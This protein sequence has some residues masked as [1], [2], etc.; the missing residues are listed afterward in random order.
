MAFNQRIINLLVCQLLLVG[1]ALTVLGLAHLTWPH[2][3]PWSASGLRQFL[4]FVFVCVALV[5]IGS[6]WS[7]QSPLVIGAFTLLGL[8]IVSGS[9][10]PLFIT[11]WLA[12]ASAILGKLV[13]SSLRISVEENWVTSLLVGAGIYG[14]IVG[15]LAHFPINYPGVYGMIL[16][17]PVLLRWRTVLEGELSFI[18]SLTKNYQSECKS[19]WL[20]LA[21]AVVA[22]IHFV[23]ALMP[24]LGH[25]ALAMHL[26]IP[27]HIASKH[28]WGF[29]AETYV[30]AVMPMLGDWIF[31]VGYMLG[32]ETA[33]RLINIGFIFVLGW[34]VRDLVLWAGGTLNGARWAALIFLSTPLTFTES[35][36]LFIESVWAAFVVSG[37]LALLR[38]SESS[39][40]SKSWI[41]HSALMLGFAVATKAV[42]LTILPVLF[43]LMLWNYKSWIKEL[44]FISW[45]NTVSLFVFFGVIPYSTAWWLTGNPVFP[46]FNGIF[47]SPFYPPVNFDSA[48]IFGKGVTWDILYRATFDSGKYLEATAG[49]SGFQWLLL[50]LPATIFL[51]LDKQRRGITLL[52]VGGGGSSSCISISE[53]LSVCVSRLGDPGVCD[54]SSVRL[55][56]K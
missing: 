26:F 21:I 15:L 40:K 48:T 3:V 2:A 10:W 12:L 36:T 56:C 49:A 30:W 39:N 7:K 6:L 41:T 19:I 17:I 51:I 9:L 4:F 25:D 20:D 24:E 31:A 38:L 8:A 1:I 35:S 14:T 34:L 23:V 22:L 50:F 27:A 45:L 54:R 53:L 37:T 47:Q 16:T 5:A 46:F 43:L 42:T 11:M 29:D 55:F 13:L 52:V 18:G 32:G 33:A 28:Q 44:S